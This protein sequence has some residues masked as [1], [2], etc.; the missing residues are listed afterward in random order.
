MTYWL[1]LGF[2]VWIGLVWILAYERFVLRGLEMNDRDHSAV[3]G[4]VVA[5]VLLIILLIV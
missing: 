1:I 4:S 3:Y 2:Y 5:A